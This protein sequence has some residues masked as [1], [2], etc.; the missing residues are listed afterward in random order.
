MFLIR[1]DDVFYDRKELKNFFAFMTFSIAQLNYSTALRALLQWRTSS[2]DSR[3]EKTNNNSINNN[4]NPT[5]RN[6]STMDNSHN[7]NNQLKILVNRNG[8]VFMQK[9]C[10]MLEIWKMEY[11]PEKIILRK[12]SSWGTSN[13]VLET[14]IN[15]TRE[16]FTP[17]DTKKQPK[18]MYFFLLLHFDSFKPSM[19]SFWSFTSFRQC[20]SSLSINLSKAISCFWR[21][22]HIF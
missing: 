17:I 9:W 5:T 10:Q 12:R 18:G 1:F 19:L 11:F 14:F 20:A 6:N 13:L 7:N 15:I 21:A 16:T 8:K 22:N 4:N 2:Q 3:L